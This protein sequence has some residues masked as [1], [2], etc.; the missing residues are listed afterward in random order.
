[1][2]NNL[3]A[4]DAKVQRTQKRREELKGRRGESAKV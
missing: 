2:L 4:K 1:M 3:N